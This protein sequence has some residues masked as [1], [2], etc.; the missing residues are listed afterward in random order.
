MILE[1]QANRLE[2][3]HMLACSALALVHFDFALEAIRIAF[4]LRCYFLLPLLPTTDCSVCTTWTTTLG[5]VQVTL[6]YA[7]LI[8]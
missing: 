4:E 1:N 5:S 3:H 8:G 6:A 7:L 2:G